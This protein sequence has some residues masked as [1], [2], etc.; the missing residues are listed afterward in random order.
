MDMKLGLTIRVRG[1]HDARQ[2]MYDLVRARLIRCDQCDHPATHIFWQ[3]QAEFYI[4]C[5]EHAEQGTQWTGSTRWNPRQ[6]WL[7]VLPEARAWVAQLSPDVQA[8]MKLEEYDAT[9]YYALLPEDHQPV[10]VVQLSGHRPTYGLFVKIWLLTN[11]DFAYE[12]QRRSPGITHTFALK[13]PFDS[14]EA[15]LDA[16]RKDIE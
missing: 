13:A 8:L 4:R 5:D 2:R 3:D 6:L 9:D 11:G 1:F 10:C 7:P 16:A 15:A 14:Q 12:R